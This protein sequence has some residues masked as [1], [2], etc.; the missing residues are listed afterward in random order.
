METLCVC[1]CAWNGVEMCCA[2]KP[3]L[4]ITI[5]V[6]CFDSQQIIRIQQ[7]HIKN[8]NNNSA[9][10]TVDWPISLVVFFPLVFGVA[11]LACSILLRLFWFASNSGI[12]ICVRIFG[13][14]SCVCICD[15]SVYDEATRPTHKNQIQ[16]ENEHDKN[17]GECEPKNVESHE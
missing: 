3:C 11:L 4:R 2:E 13:C 9:Y 16:C 14:N 10:R 6:L 17:N 8:N 15:V 5:Q 12:P 1:V 7:I